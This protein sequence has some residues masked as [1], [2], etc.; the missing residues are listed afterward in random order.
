MIF[1]AIWK[2]KNWT[3]AGMF[4]L[5]IC[6]LIPP[7]NYLI[8]PVN[9]TFFSYKETYTTLY[10][11]PGLETRQRREEPRLLFTKIFLTQRMRVIIFLGSTFVTGNTGF[12]MFF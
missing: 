12:Y 7:Q 1:H 4:L 5:P 6:Y 10:F 11:F 8:S 2:K 9:H 3:R